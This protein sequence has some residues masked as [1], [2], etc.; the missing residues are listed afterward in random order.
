MCDGCQV[1]VHSWCYGIT[2]EEMAQDKWYCLP[3][4]RGVPPRLPDGKPNPQRTCCVC[5]HIG[6]AFSITTDSK[7]I[8]TSCALYTP[9]VSFSDSAVVTVPPLPE[10]P[11]E[12]CIC[13][14]VFGITHECDYIDCYRHCHVHCIVK[15][16]LLQFILLILFIF[17]DNCLI[18]RFHYS[19]SNK[20]ITM[21]FCP[22]HSQLVD[23]TPESQLKVVKHFGKVVVQIIPPASSTTTLPVGARNTSPSTAVLSQK[24]PST[25]NS[26][27]M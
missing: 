9:T 3:C 5:N 21:M 26:S 20:D 2:P 15:S 8:H 24:V 16:L 25:Q 1:A 14:T 10:H 7:W 18:Q 17:S 27:D 13:N 19:R 12:C 4:K 6:G 23:A 22:D 11:A